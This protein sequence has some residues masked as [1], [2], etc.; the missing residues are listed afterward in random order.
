LVT[1]KELTNKE[2]DEV[3][4][5]QDDNGGHNAESRGPKREAAQGIVAGSKGQYHPCHGEQDR[6]FETLP[7]NHADQ[8]GGEGQDHGG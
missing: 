1:G 8:K 5:L 6:R 7:K 3:A 2:T 4:D